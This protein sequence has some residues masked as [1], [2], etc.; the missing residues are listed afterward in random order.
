MAQLDFSRNP[1]LTA[2]YYT[3]A[4]QLDPTKATLKGGPPPQQSAVTQA[5]QGAQSGQ[6]G[7]APGGGQWETP[8]GM[9]SAVET[10]PVQ[11]PSPTGPMWDASGGFQRPQ[12]REGPRMFTR[13]TMAQQRP[14]F[15]QF[16]D[17]I[18]SVQKRM[19]PSTRSET[20]A[21]NT[22]SQRQRAGMPTM[23]SNG[24][25]EV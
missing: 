6:Q 4:P 15:G 8:G 24:T 9:K 23:G 18:G 2:G 22:R 7:A 19:Q 25:P 12:G 1:Y 20:F 3:P 17:L 16:R 21:T 11:I 13:P 5:W 14:G 10:P